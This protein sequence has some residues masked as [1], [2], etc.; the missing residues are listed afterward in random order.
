MK[1]IIEWAYGGYNPEL[2]DK[3]RTDSSG[4]ENSSLKA[5][6]N[7]AM[8]QIAGEIIEDVEPNES[9]PDLEAVDI[10]DEIIANKE[11]TPPGESLVDFQMDET[12]NDVSS[13]IFSKSTNQHSRVK[14]LETNSAQQQSEMQELQPRLQTEMQ[15]DSATSATGDSGGMIADVSSNC[16]KSDISK[17]SLESSSTLPHCHCGLKTKIDPDTNKE[18]FYFIVYKISYRGGKVLHFRQQYPG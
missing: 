6:S 14:P 1:E 2:Y 7:Q 11:N 3:F 16:D 17:L 5:A 4:L 13:S 18:R 8:V 12:D 9:I 15:S 10:E